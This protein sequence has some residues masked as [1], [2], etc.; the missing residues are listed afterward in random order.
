MEKQDEEVIDR[1]KIWPSKY[2]KWK[3]TVLSILDYELEPRAVVE[4]TLAQDIH[5]ENLLFMYTR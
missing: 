3:M 4:S 5:L 1:K 2:R